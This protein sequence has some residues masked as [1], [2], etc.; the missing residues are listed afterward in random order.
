[1]L[2]I[3]GTITHSSDWGA[4]LLNQAGIPARTLAGSGTL[5]SNIW[6]GND[7]LGA[8]LPDGAYRVLILATNQADGSVSAAYGDW[9]SLDRTFPTANLS[10][11][12]LPDGS[13]A[14]QVVIRG[15]ARDTGAFVGYALD[16]GF[17]T[18]PVAFTLLLS[19][20]VPVTQ[21]ILGQINSLGLS[22]GVYTF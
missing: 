21:G 7:G 4:I 11:T 20:T 2:T 15:D 18:N 5:I 16:Y 22:N 17:G 10:I 6:D 1:T 3:R 8:P 9:S 14:N 13:V 19:N 12:T